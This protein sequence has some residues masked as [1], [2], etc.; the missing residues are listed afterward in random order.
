[1]TGPF[2][3]AAGGAPGGAPPGR[4]RSGTRLLGAGILLWAVA[5]LLPVAATHLA[6]GG[7]QVVMWLASMPLCLLGACMA[8]AGWLRRRRAGSASWE[9]RG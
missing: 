1:M 6:S 3:N 5:A 7:A 2:A 8:I 9:D 4:S